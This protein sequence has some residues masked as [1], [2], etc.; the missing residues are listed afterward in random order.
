MGEVKFTCLG[1]EPEET[2]GIQPSH[3]VL[4]FTETELFLWLE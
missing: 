4:N 1:F 3:S 2:Y